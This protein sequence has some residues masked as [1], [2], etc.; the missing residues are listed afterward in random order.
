MTTAVATE[1]PVR[2]APAGDPALI[3]VPTFIVG[4]IALGLVVAGY[5]PAG[6]VGRRSRSSG[7][8]P[9]RASSSPRCGRPRWART[10]SPRCSA[11]S[12]GFLSARISC[13]AG[14]A[15]VWGFGWRPVRLLPRWSAV[16]GRQW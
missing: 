9:V 1:A 7:R 5:V 12:P 4:A 15:A 10:P 16:D 3:G 11:C 14:L 13:P 2:T 8:P 6:A